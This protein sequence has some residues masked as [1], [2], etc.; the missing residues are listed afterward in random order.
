MAN[1]ILEKKKI[2]LYDAYE[3]P[4]VGPAGGELDQYISAIAKAQLK[5]QVNN[6]YLTLGMKVK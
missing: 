2:T 4:L 5:L 6:M 3:Y 1:A